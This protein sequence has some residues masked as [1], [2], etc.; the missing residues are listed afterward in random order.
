MLKYYAEMSGLSENCRVQHCNQTYLDQ[1]LE[2]FQERFLVLIEPPSKLAHSEPQSLPNRTVQG[3][4]GYSV[5][6]G[7]I[8][9]A[10]EALLEAQGSGS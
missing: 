4:Q 2:F 3:A 6:A 10:V 9:S 5:T 7:E 8:F 1:S